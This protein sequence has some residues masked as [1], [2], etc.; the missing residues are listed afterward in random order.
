VIRTADTC[1]C[2]NCTLMANRNV[3]ARVAIVLVLL[4]PILLLAY[5]YNFTSPVFSGVPFEYSYVDGDSA[6]RELPIFELVDLNGDTL[7]R[8]ELLG[9]V[10]I[11]DFFSVDDDDGS[12]PYPLATV[13][14]GNIKRLYDNVAWEK[15]PE[16]VMISVNTG[17]T[18]PE[19]V[20]Y[21]QDFK[22]RYS[23][24]KPIEDDRWKFVHGNLEDVYRIG[25]GAFGLDG[26]VG[27]KP[28]DVSFTAK[29]AALIDKQGMVRKFYVATDLQS[30]RK[31]FEDYIALLR[32]EY[33]DEVDRMRGRED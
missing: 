14:H 16:I 15:E 13:L 23:E 18:L 24:N 32:M 4:V 33:S 12:L 6:K 20:R 17:D 5:F 1:Q 9:K 22:R 11:M 3:Q 8:E 19:I 7:N 26:F 10:V 27:H 31:I 2:W 28:G 30:E 29:Q 21:V 25:Q